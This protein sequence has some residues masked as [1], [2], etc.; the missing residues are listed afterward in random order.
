MVLL[1]AVCML[2]ISFVNCWAD[3][4]E[5]GRLFDFAAVSR[6]DMATEAPAGNTQFFCAGAGIFDTAAAPQEKPVSGCAQAADV[7]NHGAHRD[8]GL[9]DTPN[10]SVVHIYENGLRAKAAHLN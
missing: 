5:M 10:Q 7:G 8:T 2:R 1:A 6:Q 9:A 4:E 3:G